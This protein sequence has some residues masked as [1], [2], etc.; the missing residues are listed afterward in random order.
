MMGGIATSSLLNFWLQIVIGLMLVVFCIGL[1]LFLFGWWSGW[2]W[3]VG[4][5]H[6]GF[7]LCS[8]ER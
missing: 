7:V 2:L 6:G 3:V 5:G 1:L 8:L 4:V